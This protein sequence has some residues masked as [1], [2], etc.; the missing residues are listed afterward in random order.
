MITDLGTWRSQALCLGSDVGKWYSPA[1]K[2]IKELRDICQ[3]CPVRTDCLHEALTMPGKFARHGFRAGAT[4]SQI[5]LLRKQTA[6]GT[7]LFRCTCTT[8]LDAFEYIDAEK[9]FVCLEC[10]KIV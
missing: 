7:A 3:R 8:R 1:K 5:A 6:N 9:Y 4:P 2:D 10:E